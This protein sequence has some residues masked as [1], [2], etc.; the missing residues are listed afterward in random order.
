HELGI[1][2]WEVI[3]AAATKPFGFMPF[4]PG[5]GIGG[6]CIPLDP[7]YLSW[8]V[9]R[10]TGRRFGVLEAAQDVN[11]RMP[12]YV[13]TRVAEI[14]NDVG[15]PVRSSRI[16]V[17]GVTYKADVGDVRESPGL[18]VLT[19]LQQRGAEVSYHDP[20][21]PA[22]FLSFGELHA[23]PDLD[24]ALERADLVVL[25]TPHPSYDLDD[26]AERSR[27]V[28]DTR[29]AYRGVGPENVIPL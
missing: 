20:F 3:D 19:A 26:I 9:R 10:R 23:E 24:G 29:N 15:R 14:L 16:L 17:L 1:D 5:P 4:Y 25:V 11:D 8:E 22:V 21:V 7:T 28:F 6:H 13:A 27:V 2:L 18:A 12:A